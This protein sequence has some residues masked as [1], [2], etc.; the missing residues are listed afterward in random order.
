MSTLV[1]KNNRQLQMSAKGSSR[2]R[3]C[4]D[5]DHLYGKIRN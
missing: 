2:E 5:R 4:K 3:K 1:A